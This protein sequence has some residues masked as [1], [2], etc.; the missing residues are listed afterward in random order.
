MAI[1]YDHTTGK[2]DWNTPQLL[3]DALNL[4]FSFTLD[5]AATKA[6]AK[7][8][9]YFTPEDD[10]LKQT[11]HGRVFVN[12]PFSNI[13]DWLLKAWQSDCEII[14]FLVPARTDTQWWHQYV[15]KANEVRFTIDRPHF[16]DPVTNVGKRAP[17]GCAIVVF[18]QERN[19]NNKPRF[20]SYDVRK[21]H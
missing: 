4:E 20:S 13:K 2:T 5:A 17:F 12:P 10:G 7:C 19:V 18:N 15:M 14:V 6:S 1:W 16:V 3:F 9:K 21:M 8:L 11:W